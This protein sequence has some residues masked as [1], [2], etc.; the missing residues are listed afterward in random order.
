M[1]KELDKDLR[2]LCDRGRITTTEA[3]ELQKE[4][5]RRDA[6][7]DARCQ[8]E[9]KHINRRLRSIGQGGRRRHAA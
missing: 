4:R 1:S 7:I 5:N 9:G 2:S 6:A 8:D 3:N